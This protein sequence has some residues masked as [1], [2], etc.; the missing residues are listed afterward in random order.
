MRLLLVEDRRLRDAHLAADLVNRRAQLLLLERAGNL[1]L[2]DL[3]LGHAG[4]STFGS[5]DRR[6][7]GIIK[8]IWLS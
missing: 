4:N 2:S 5:T 8:L 7:G 1:L 3:V 6:E